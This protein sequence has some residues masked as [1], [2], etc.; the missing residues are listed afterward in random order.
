MSSV[1]GISFEI[2]YH[3][4][5]T[6]ELF[7]RRNDYIVERNIINHKFKVSTN[8][9]VMKK[10][11]LGAAVVAVTMLAS[12]SG[13]SDN[14]AQSTSDFKTKIENCTNPD[15][16]TVY[17]E[18]AKA[19]AQKLVSEGKVEEAKKYIDRIEPV[20]KE[21]APGLAG[22]FETVKKA[23]A[24]VPGAVADKAADVKDAVSDK[25]E[26][27]VDAVGDKTKE[28]TSAVKDKANDAVEAVADKASDLKDA[29]GEKATEVK[30]A[31]KDKASDVKEAVKDKASDVKEA[32]KDKTSDIKDAVKDKVDDVKDAV[33]DKLENLK[34]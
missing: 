7:G 14:K 1:D 23:L 26:D 2:F 34:K 15:S 5:F 29:A 16:L 30:D 22:T 32:V 10:L 8:Q 11:L 19:Y 21:K 4:S 6:P 31:I 27:I 12:C 25:T 20:V 18:Q 13:S 33:K 24:K 3:I 9:K 28:I 17:V